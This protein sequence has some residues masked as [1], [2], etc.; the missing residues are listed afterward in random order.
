MMVRCP[1]SEGLLQEPLLL[2]TQLSADEH[3]EAEGE[4]SAGG[5]LLPTC[6]AWVEFL[7]WSCPLCIW[8]MS[9]QV[10]SFSVL[11]YGARD[12][13][14]V[15]FIRSIMLGG[16]RTFKTCASAQR[17]MSRQVYY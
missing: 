5:S 4:D 16:E 7:A 14:V 11:K 6:K 12:F 9:W 17:G 13:L 8:V 10:K 1:T 2:P 15:S 3:Q